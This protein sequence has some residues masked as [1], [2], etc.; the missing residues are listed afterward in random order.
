MEDARP[1][2]DPPVDG[3]SQLQ[4][5][6]NSFHL[7][8]TSWDG[9]LRIHDTKES[10]LKCLQSM[11]CGPLL[12]L[13]TSTTDEH[14]IYTGGLDGS[15]RA[16]D[17]QASNTKIVGK[18]T[19]ADNSDSNQA[20]VACSCLAVLDQ[21]RLVS[22]GWHGKLHIHDTRQETPIQT[23]DLP[24]KAYSMDY[25][26]KYHRLVVAC[27]G[28]R[29]VLIDTAR[30]TTTG[31]ILQERESTLKYQTR[32]IRLFGDDV[33]VLGSIEGRVAVEY[34]DP[35]KKGYAFKCHRQNDTVYPVN[36]LEFHPTYGTFAT[37]G[38]DGTV[39]TWDGVA[40][41]KI[42][43]LGKFPTSIAALAFASDGSEVAI[44]SS[45]TYEEGERE[46]PR[47]EIYVRGLTALEVKPKG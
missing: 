18:H 12:S 46:H 11:D 38:C 22:A 45:Y 14:L 10:Q 17:V 36:C 19:A 47:D 13:A 26:H 27:S 8:S 1:L 39:V 30:I 5:I 6:G 29:N 24:G 44:A 20:K 35:N 2:P 4:Y 43:S 15:I 40:K 33:I 25:D 34:V 9:G 21:H 37:G 3:I 42:A 31:S 32:C 41:K 16:F 7:A 23:I 28:R